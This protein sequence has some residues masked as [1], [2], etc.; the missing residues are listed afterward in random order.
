[1][2]LPDLP[3]L[4]SAADKKKVRFER[5]IMPPPTFITLPREIRDMVYHFVWDHAPPNGATSLSPD[6]TPFR[7]HIYPFDR[8]PIDVTLALLHVN[9][10]ISAEAALIFYGKRT[11]YFDPKDVIPFLRR[12][13][14]R[15]DLIK[16]IEVTEGSFFFLRLYSKIFAVL[17]TLGGPKSFAISLNL[18]LTI[19][20]PFERVLERLATVGIHN[21]TDR[22]NVSVR[23]VGRMR[24]DSTED[25]QTAIKLTETW[26]CAKGE[27]HWKKLGLQC[28]AYQRGMQLVYHEHPL[29]QLC[30]HE[31]HRRMFSNL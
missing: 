21:V 22:M 19:N 27:R 8:F 11:F 6:R 4:A 24:Q 14:H 26:T 23:F 25:C 31:D 17:P 12:F 7:R 13:P 9:R 29:G 1:M 3:F 2:M 18:F 20:R 10:Q 28:R 5:V 15:L 30:D 16:D